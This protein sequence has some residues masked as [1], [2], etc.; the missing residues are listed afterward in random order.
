MDSYF[1]AEPDLKVLPVPLS[2]REAIVQAFSSMRHRS[3]DHYTRHYTMNLS[4]EPGEGGTVKGLSAMLAIQIHAG[5]GSMSVRRTGW[6]R[7]LFAQ[8]E[9]E[10]RIARRVLVYDV[11][12]GT[13]ASTR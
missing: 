4:V 5:D 13:G 10:W 2:G 3:K 7:D 11:L 1:T 6:Y 12:K 9:G 8:E